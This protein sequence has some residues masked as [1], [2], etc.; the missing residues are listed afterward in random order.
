MKKIKTLTIGI[1]AHNEEANIAKLLDSVLSQKRDLFKLEKIIVACDGCTDKTAVI[2]TKYAK[3]NKFIRVINDGKR[4]GKAER[5]NHFYKNN[6][7]DI[8]LILDADV[9]LSHKSVI[10]E[11]VNKFDSQKVGLVGGC[12]L[13]LPPRNFFER[14]IYTWLSIWF[15]IRRNLNN[16]DSVHNNLGC[17]SALS[18]EFAK[19]VEIPNNLIPDDDFTYFTAIKTGY[20]FKFAEKAIV[21]YRTVDNLNDF[22]PQHSRLLF[23]K[24]FVAEQFGDW[25][26]KYYKTQLNLKLEAIG[27]SMLLNPLFTILAL[28]LQIILRE[29]SVLHKENYSGGYWKTAISSKNLNQSMKSIY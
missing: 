29:A 2:A 14:I 5:L 15:E 1:S 13:P 12:N 18:R 4:L 3:S 9:V 8:I 10:D 20:K 17:V 27:K 16:G 6:K 21:F 19:K 23:S 26:N 25:V 7:S 24:K 11:I 28:V 22:F